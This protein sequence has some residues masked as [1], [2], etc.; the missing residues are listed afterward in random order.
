MLQHPSHRIYR[1]EVAALV[2]GVEDGEACDVDGP[3]GPGETWDDSFKHPLAAD[4]P[5]GQ[6]GVKGQK[7]AEMELLV[8]LLVWQCE[9]AA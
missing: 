6:A 8:A 7:N 9:S 5:G 3:G 4:G 2:A 1:R